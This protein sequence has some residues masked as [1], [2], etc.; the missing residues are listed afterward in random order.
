MDQKEL[1]EWSDGN[2]GAL[3][4]LCELIQTPD[5]M[6]KVYPILESTKSIR[7]T[8]LYILYSD[9][10]GKDL[11]MVAL[12]CEKCPKGILE[13]ACNRQDRSGCEL[14]WDYLNQTTSN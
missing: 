8:N 1:I 10:C 11:N 4:F 5:I 2:P 12:L 13:D 7:G 6:D 14:V 3:S 9:L